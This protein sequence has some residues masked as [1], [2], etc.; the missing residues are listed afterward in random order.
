MRQA[1]PCHLFPRCAGPAV[2][3]VRVDADTAAGQEF[4]PYFDVFRIH[5]VDQVIHDDVDTVFMEIAMI[6]ETEQIEFQ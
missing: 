3:A 2:V 4:P 6:A 1:L 5:G